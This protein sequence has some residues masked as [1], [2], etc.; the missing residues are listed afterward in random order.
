VLGKVDKRMAELDALSIGVVSI[1]GRKGWSSRSWAGCL[2]QVGA[3]RKES[4]WVAVSLLKGRDASTETDIIMGWCTV[5]VMHVSILHSRVYDRFVPCTH[6]D[7]VYSSRPLPARPGASC[8]N[9]L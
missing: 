5:C 4:S 9:V 2:K 6:G 7:G 8:V 1:A 3:V